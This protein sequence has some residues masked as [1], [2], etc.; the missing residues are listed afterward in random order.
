[1][2]N[3]TLLISF[4]ILV[5][6]MLVTFLLS[7]NIY[8]PINRL[9]D[10]ATSLEAMR[11]DNYNSFRQEILRNLLSQTPNANIMLK[12]FKEFNIKLDLS[13][14]FILV[15]LKIDR[16]V[17]EPSAEVP[18]E[19][20]TSILAEVQEAVS[21][22][23]KLSVSCIVSEYIHGAKNI[24]TGFAKTLEMSSYRLIY[25][26]S[27]IILLPELAKNIKTDEL[28]YPA[29]KEKQLLDSLMLG[30]PEK[31][32]SIYL[33]MLKC[34]NGYSYNDLMAFLTRLAL[35]INSLA[36][37]LR[38]TASCSVEFDFYTFNKILN[39]LE[40]L[41][42]INARFESIFEEICDILV[43]KKEDIYSS[44]IAS[45]TDYIKKN[46]QDPNLSLNIIAEYVNKSPVYLGRVFKK[47]TGKS[48]SDCINE[49]RLQKSKELLLESRFTIEEICDHVGISNEKY[50]YIFF[51]KLTGL[52][53]NEYRK[54]K[55]G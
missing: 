30:N 40:T 37:N 51:K 36:A 27:S 7:R 2:R 15:I 14:N 41:D 25:G 46:Y 24:C 33:E 38:N 16:N 12:N 5:L 44:L 48:V 4:I 52:T 3:Y 9:I 55:R 49:V 6:A 22:H 28:K 42:E 34:T 35:A 10:K 21:K 20:I 43:V 47:I 17:D 39:K 32:M 50:F 26:H 1:M 19:K 53:P 18:Y 23:L 29:N 54:R 31:A 45:I 11:R 13:R 8:P